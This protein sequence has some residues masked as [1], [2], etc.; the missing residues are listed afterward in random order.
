[1]LFYVE[2]EGEQEWGNGGNE[3]DKS[4]RDKKRKRQCHVF[5]LLCCCAVDKNAGEYMM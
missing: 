5:V 2:S 3:V 1:M 4:T